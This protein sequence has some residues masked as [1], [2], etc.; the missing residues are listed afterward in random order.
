MDKIIWQ[1]GADA[2]QV[3]AEM[4]RAIRGGKTFSVEMEKSADK[5]DAGHEKILRSGHRVSKQIVNVSKDMLSGA[6]SA[7]VLA[8]SLE[9][10]ARSLN[11]SLGALAALG[12]GA[13]IGQQIH[14]VIEEF[15]T[16][17]K[18]LSKLH[19]E[20]MQDGKWKTVSQLEEVAK[21][22]EESLKE[23]QERISAREA[24]GPR[25]FGQ[26]LKDMVVDAWHAVTMPGGSAQADKAGLTAGYADKDKN[27]ADRLTKRQQQ[28]GLKEAELAGA[29]SDAV[30][31]AQVLI[32]SQ[33]KAATTLDE[34]EQVAREVSIALQEIVKTG[35]NVKK[36]ERSGMSVKELAA[37]PE[38]TGGYNPDGTA[39][40]I[41]YEQWKAGQDARSAMAIDAQAESARLNFQP[42]VAH[43]LFNQAG[44]AKES[45]TNLKPSEKMS[46]DFKGALQVTEGK[47]EEI[48]GNTAG[49]FRGR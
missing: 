40:T 21:R 43:D 8:G 16:L 20:A 44:E 2:S 17:Q 7:D 48:A 6:S 24:G 22:A 42:E 10:I 18:R 46:A 12:V 38:A 45:I 15:D 4:D 23:L 49:M 31:A 9:G 28:S 39:W 32:A 29:P 47:L 13:V 30:K 35:N 41:P 11:I 19:E 1:L 25:G 37:I 33:E 26:R 34:M 5:V 36:S 27:L 3:H 14:K